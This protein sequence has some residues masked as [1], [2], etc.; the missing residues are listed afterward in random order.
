M[1]EALDITVLDLG[2]EVAELPVAVRIECEL[3]GKVLTG[4]TVLMQPD[5]TG[6]LEVNEAFR[7][8]MPPSGELALAIQRALCSQDVED[9]DIFMVVYGCSPDESSAPAAPTRRSG[10]GAP[11]CR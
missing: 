7:A 10:A 6:V 9:S 3:P 4:R 5:E 8:A 2:L 11:R 1:A